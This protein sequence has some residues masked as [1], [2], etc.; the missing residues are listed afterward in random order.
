[1]SA[2]REP[3]WVE[4]LVRVLRDTP[5]LPGALCVQRSVVFDADQDDPEGREYAIARA[6]RLCS[7][8]P[9]LAVCRSWA[10]TQDRL[11]GVVAG[12]VRYFQ[13]RPAA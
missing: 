1:M 12:Q 8:C 9:C 11:V 4:L 6:K 13:E 3:G 7:S 2:H 5:K 10:D